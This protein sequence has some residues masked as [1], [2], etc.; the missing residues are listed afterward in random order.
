VCLEHSQS[1]ENRSHVICKI[2]RFPNTSIHVQE[3]S[4]RGSCCWTTYEKKTEVQLRSPTNES[5]EINS[6]SGTCKT[7]REDGESHRRSCCERRV[8]W[9]FYSWSQYPS[10]RRLFQEKYLK[11]NVDTLRKIGES[12]S[13]PVTEEQ[14]RNLE[15][16]TTKQYDCLWWYVMK[17]GR[18][19]ASNFK[20]V[21][22]TS[23]TNVSMSVLKKVCYPEK[24]DFFQKLRSGASITRRTDCKRTLF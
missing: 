9:A 21:C 24:R 22:H 1:S 15:R 4:P 6:Y 11:E 8:C 14:R 16:K 13:L 5:G 23:F 10:L 19:T 7:F 20:S 3:G 18:V 12:L 17:A 2:H